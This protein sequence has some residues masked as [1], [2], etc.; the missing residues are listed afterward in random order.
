MKRSF[1]L[2]L[3]GML[4]V[5]FA[6]SAHAQTASAQGS[7]VVQGQACDTTGVCFDSG[8]RGVRITFNFDG[9]GPGGA[10]PVTGTWTVSEADTGVVI[11]FVMGTAIVFRSS[12]QLSASG[13]CRVTTPT[14][15]PMLGFCS[16]FA[17]DSTSNGAVDVVSVF[18]NA[19]NGFLSAFGELASGN[20]NIE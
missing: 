20:F 13:T 10:V 3:T 1:F 19:P 11:E 9:S 15:L 14:S 7:G 2:A 8:G 12:H 4:C 6:A 16:L 5:G 17:Q 18:A